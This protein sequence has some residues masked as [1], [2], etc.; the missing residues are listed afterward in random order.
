MI[1]VVVFTWAKHEVPPI[2][3]IYVEVEVLSFHDRVLCYIA[4]GN[5]IYI[6]GSA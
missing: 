1:A 3:T 2:L 5:P 4:D 6:N